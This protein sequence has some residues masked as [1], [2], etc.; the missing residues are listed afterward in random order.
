MPPTRLPLWIICAL[1]G[2]AIKDWRDG[3]R[4]KKV[5]REHVEDGRELPAERT[6]LKS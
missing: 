4:G 6:E 3:G 1:C 5:C 2:K